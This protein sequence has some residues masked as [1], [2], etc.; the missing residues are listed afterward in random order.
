MSDDERCRRSKE[1]CTL[2][3][4]G[5]RVMARVRITMLRFKG[6]SDR[7]SVERGQH[8]SN[9]LSGISTRTM[10]QSTTPSLSQTI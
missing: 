3:L 2:E 6:N 10:Q 9:R 8:S 7:D 5:Q 4:I 1:V